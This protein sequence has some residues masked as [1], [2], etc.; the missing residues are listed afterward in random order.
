LIHARWAVLGALGCIFPEALEATNNVPW[1]KA[2]AYIF[3]EGGLD[4]LGNSGLIHAQSTL[5]VPGCQVVLM[6]LI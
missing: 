6:G 1:F 2:G 5:A 4:Y 3:S